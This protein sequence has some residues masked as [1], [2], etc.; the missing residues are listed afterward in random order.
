MKSH[1][2]V[3]GDRTNEAVWSAGRGE[4]GEVVRRVAA[5]ALGDGGREGK[6]GAIGQTQDEGWGREPDCGIGLQCFDRVTLRSCQ[7][8]LTAAIAVC[9]GLGYRLV[10]GNESIH[11]DVEPETHQLDNRQKNQPGSYSSARPMSKNGWRRMRRVRHGGRP[12][13][14]EPWARGRGINADRYQYSS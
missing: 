2:F 7:D 8:G 9:F 12:A 11:A 10:A 6:G 1:V 13:L 5:T 3:E 14:N 4:L